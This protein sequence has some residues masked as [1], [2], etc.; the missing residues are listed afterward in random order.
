[1]EN[2]NSEGWML[3]TTKEVVSWTG[4]YEVCGQIEV[5][6]WDDWKMKWVE[7]AGMIKQRSAG[8]P[9]RAEQTVVLV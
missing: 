5:R 9:V 6:Y 7:E 8:W 3:K 4:S 2:L 1:M